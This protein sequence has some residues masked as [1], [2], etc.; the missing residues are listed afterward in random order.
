MDIDWM[1]RAWEVLGLIWY[2]EEA[3]AF[4]DPLTEE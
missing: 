2:H 1:Q 3:G 4:L